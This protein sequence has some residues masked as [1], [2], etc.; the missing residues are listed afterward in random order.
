MINC[1]FKIVNALYNK[2]LY[3]INYLPFS[4]STIKILIDNNEDAAVDILIKPINSQ[5]NDD[6]CGGFDDDNNG[7]K[8][9]WGGGASAFTSKVPG[10]VPGSS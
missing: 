6:F 8:I 9:I 4:I 5:N 10:G 3:K 1:N 7:L 2:P